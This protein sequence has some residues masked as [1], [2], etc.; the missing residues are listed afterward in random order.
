MKFDCVK[1]SG[2]V[3]YVRSVNPISGGHK[4][5]VSVDG[6]VIPNL[7]VS[8][9]LYEELEAGQTATLYGIFNRS[10][11]KEKNHGV[12]YGLTQRGE[13]IFDTSQRFKVP[14]AMAGF[15]VIAFCMMFVIGW[16]PTLF[17][18][19]LLFGPDPDV[20]SNA[21]VLAAVEGAFAALFFLWRAQVMLSATANPEAWES[22]DPATL[23]SRFSKFHK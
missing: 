11:K 1:F 10:K 12:L 19:G 6:A 7:Q 5:K 9:K 23:S 14:V 8:N 13:K 16:V 21:T 20:F 2:K 18:L 3:D 22:I 17:A 4:I 15:A